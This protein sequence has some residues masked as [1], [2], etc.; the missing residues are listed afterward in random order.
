MALISL[1]QE[2]TRC[3]NK[4]NDT[5]LHR[6]CGKIMATCKYCS[7]SIT[8]MKEGRKNIPV[9]DDGSVHECEQFKEMRRSAKKLAPSEIDPEI[10]KQYQENM[11]KKLKK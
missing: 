2:I 11:L 6:A 5:G 8:W 9:E 7:K 1:G 4:K 10:L 3:Y